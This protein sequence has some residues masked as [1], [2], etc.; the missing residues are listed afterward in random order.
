MPTSGQRRRISRTSQTPPRPGIRRSVTTIGV[1]C[2]SSSSS[3]CSAVP[4]AWH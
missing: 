1:S 2:F 4:A 3:A